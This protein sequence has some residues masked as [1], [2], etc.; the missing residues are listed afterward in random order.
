MNLYFLQS[1]LMHNNPLRRWAAQRLVFLFSVLCIAAAA[2]FLVET[3]Y[4]QLRA[5]K[6]QGEIVRVYKRQGDNFMDR[7][8]TLYAP[9][10]RYIWS[11]G[12]P[13][14]ASA[15]QA[16]ANRFSIGEKHTILFDPSTKTDVR[17][18]RFDQ[19]WALPVTLVSI[20]IV[21]WLLA[22]PIWIW[23]IRPRI[24]RARERRIFIL[25]GSAGSD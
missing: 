2:L 22:L 17:T 13:T 6:T 8:K 24:A 9:V 15:G 4:F 21:T 14:D 1:H 19:L 20:G 11:D 10:F 7:G 3:I 12:K 23:L 18:T 16:F 5:Q 25:P